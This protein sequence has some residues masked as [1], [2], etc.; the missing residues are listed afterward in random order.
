MRSDA[1]VDLFDH[2]RYCREVVSRVHELVTASGADLV[3]HC[4]S[5]SH[6]LR[7]LLRA[8]GTRGRVIG[9]RFANS[10][11]IHDWLDPAETVALAVGH[12]PT[13]NVVRATSSCRLGLKNQPFSRSRQSTDNPSP[14]SSEATGIQRI[15]RCSECMQRSTRASSSPKLSPVRESSTPTLSTPST[16]H[17]L[18]YPLRSILR[19]DAEESPSVRRIARMHVCNAA[20]LTP[21]PAQK[22][23]RR[24]LF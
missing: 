12:V 6:K 24:S 13:K 10:D 4:S 7:D 9:D 11:G 2:H 20:S 8:L 1:H 22:W 5:A 14:A 19:I 18:I 17:A 15:I 23:S 3:R 21:L 16:L